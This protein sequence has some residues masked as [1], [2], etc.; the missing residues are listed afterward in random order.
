MCS[1]VVG[2]TFIEDNTHDKMFI[3]SVDIHKY[4]YLSRWNHSEY[5]QKVWTDIH[6]ASISMRYLLGACKVTFAQ[7]LTPDF[8][9][10]IVDWKNP[11]LGGKWNS[12]SEIDSDRRSSSS[13][14]HKFEV[15]LRPHGCGLLVA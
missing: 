7:G 5:Y 11:L 14:L 13:I 1:D 12:S 15:M 9:V 4:G 2:T 10:V 6:E 3:L 8:E